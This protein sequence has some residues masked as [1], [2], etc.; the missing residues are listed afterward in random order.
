MKYAILITQNCNLS[1]SYC[2]ISKKNITMDLATARKTIDFIFNQTPPNERIDIGF[3]GGEPLL[4]FAQ[5]KEINALFENHPEFK[6]R[7]IEIQI[8]SNGTIFSN[9]IAE[10]LIDKKI[11]FGLSCDGIPAV[12][13]TCRKTEKGIGMS[14]K[15]LKNI[16]KAINKLPNVMVNAVFTPLTLGYL[17]E[18]LEY[19]YS[20]GFRKI[21]LNPDFRSNWT[22]ANVE[23]LR[24]E[25]KKIAE[26]YIK[27]HCE[28]K[29]AYVSILDGKI[30]VILNKGYKPN[31]RCQMGKKEFAITPEGNIFPCERLVENGDINNSHC[32]GNI[33]Q[34]IKHSQLL[35]SKHIN[36]HNN[37]PCKECSFKKYCMNWCGCSNYF[38]TGYY[39]QIGPFIC[40][41]EKATMELASFAFQQ[42]ESKYGMEIIMKMQLLN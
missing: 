31:E 34:G 23:N 7:N 27:W 6:K 9:E 18:S 33:Y 2:F 4:E 22:I 42:L 29:P 28:N 35:C 15:I 1:C 17:A 37:L 39:N 25:L 11:G 3:F 26:L 19:L 32:I 14:D 21:Y 38:S 20:L 36:K 40:A 30:G 16:Q 10:F 5:L 41:F 12:Q 8:I 24:I 13:D